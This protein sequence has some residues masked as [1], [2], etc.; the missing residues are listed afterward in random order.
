MFGMDT[1]LGPLPVKAL[2]K[3]IHPDDR[4]IAVRVREKLSNKEEILVL[5]IRTDPQRGPIRNLEVS[6]F[7]DENEEGHFV[8]RGT[9]RDITER[10]EHQKA[11]RQYDHLA[12]LG[13][14]SAGI[15]HEINNPIGGVLLAA[16]Y[17]LD[18]MKYGIRT[19]DCGK[20]TPGD[21]RGCEALS[22]H[23]EI[24]PTV[25]PTGIVSK[26]TKQSE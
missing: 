21:R 17:T 18:S 25:R 9:V 20:S 13:T 2:L 16:Q 1:S 10:E 15:A 7:P 26:D 23:R 22:P 3:Y 6:V 4:E 11:L 14:L 24:R 12:S 5:D 19:H 8:F